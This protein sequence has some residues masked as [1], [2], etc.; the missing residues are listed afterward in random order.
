MSE[1]NQRHE[2]LTTKSGDE[3]DLSSLFNY[4]A[5]GKLFDSSGDQALL[6][7]RARLRGTAERLDRIIRQGSR[8]EADRATTARRA[9]TLTEELLD[10]LE[11]LRR[12]TQ[13]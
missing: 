1:I 10:S 4:P 2:D 12:K 5:I 8:E 3:T 6:E 13:G 11:T 7:M 9:L